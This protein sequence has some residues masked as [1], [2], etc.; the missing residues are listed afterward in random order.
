MSFIKTMKKIFYIPSSV[1]RRIGGDLSIYIGRLDRLI[2]S[3]D[4]RMY[5]MTGGSSQLSGYYR[6]TQFT[7]FVKAQQEQEAAEQ[8]SDDAVRAKR[9]IESIDN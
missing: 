4:R 7:D 1:M 2:N 5:E 3:L 9:E 6:Y 8:R